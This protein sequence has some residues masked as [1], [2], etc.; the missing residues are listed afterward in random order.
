MDLT[1]ETPLTVN[2][3]LIEK[4]NHEYITRNKEALN[5]YTYTFDI[6]ADRFYHY[7][8]VKRTKE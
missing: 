4:E 5:Q 1:K 3:S 7:T 6:A 2:T 8:G